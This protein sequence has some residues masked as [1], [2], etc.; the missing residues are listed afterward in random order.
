MV[1]SKNPKTPQKLFKHKKIAPSIPKK[2][3]LGSILGK[4]LWTRNL[5]FTPFQNG[6]RGGQTDKKPTHGH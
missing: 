3:V 2:Y 4:R 5:Y 6:V 1:W